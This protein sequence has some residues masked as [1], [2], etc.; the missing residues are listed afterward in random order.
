MSDT[1]APYQCILPDICPETVSAPYSPVQKLR[2]SNL[3][4]NHASTK[5]MA[6]FMKSTDILHG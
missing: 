3:Y 1:S 2:Y 5:L 4:Q 6:K